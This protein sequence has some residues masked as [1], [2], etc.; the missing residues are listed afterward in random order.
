MPDMYF[1]QELHEDCG[2]SAYIVGSRP[3]REVMVVDPAVEIEPY[4]EL[5]R[6][7]GFR[8]LSVIDTHIHA[9]HVSGARALAAATGAEL[10]L[11]RS[12]EVGFPFRPLDDGDELHAGQ[13]RLRVLHTPGHR[14]E[15]ISLLVINDARSHEPSMVLTGDTLLVGDVGRPD[16]G[17]EA[18]A[19][20]LFQSVNRLLE[21][22]DWVEV[23]PGHF[24]GPC[25][26]GMCGRPSTTIG[27][28]RRYNP[29]LEPL[30]EQPDGAEQ[31]FVQLISGTVPAKPLNMDAIIAT[32]VGQMAAGWASPHGMDPVPE[33][34]LEAA[35]A[36]IAEKR[37]FIVDVREPH[38]YAAFH[39][40]GAVSIPQCELADRLAE[41]PRDGELLIVCQSG[42][43]S[44][45]AT[46]FLRQQGFANAV[47]LVGGSG[48]WKERGYPL[49]EGQPVA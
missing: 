46:R 36:F 38:E 2:C 7:H 48:G 28:E 21:L 11:H 13:V 23:F 10:C 22:P 34:A 35:P 43:R 39:L 25:G 30:R 14:P 15:A 33:L 4:L 26:K 32:N 31:A 20:S 47:N 37:P 29:V 18:G 12:A 45:R 16:F 9:D 5:T 49:E 17:G 27:F 44:E 42:A 19:R 3:A 1:H 24:D 41:L 6:Q 40:P 8:I